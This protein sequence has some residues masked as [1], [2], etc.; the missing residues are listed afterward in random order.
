VTAARPL[1]LASVRL[2][3]ELED[4]YSLEADLLDDRRF[5]EWLDLLHADI[6]YRIPMSQNVHSKRAA[7]EFLTDDLAVCWM[8]EGKRTLTQRVEQFKTGLHWAEEPMSR[9]CHL[10]TNTRVLESGESDGARRAKAKTRFLV[11]RNR[12]QSDVDLLVGKRVDDLVA[13]ADA[14]WKV[15]SRTVYLDQTVLLANN[16]TTFL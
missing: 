5:D 12:L 4:F 16:L 8:D 2:R 9:T 6:R 15:L 3:L 14:G 10:Y 1:D 13:D 7:S 11:Y